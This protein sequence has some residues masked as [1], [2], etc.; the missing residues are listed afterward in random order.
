[1]TRGQ[2]LAAAITAKPEHVRLSIKTMLAFDYA[3]PT[4]LLLQIEAEI[5]RASC[6]ERVSVL[7]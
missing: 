1:M 3:E 2:T 7:V 5:G 4:D 6:R